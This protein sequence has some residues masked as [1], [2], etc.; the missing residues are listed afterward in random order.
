MVDMGHEEHDPSR[1]RVRMTAVLW[2]APVVLVST[3]FCWAIVD[4]S[5]GHVEDTGG[6]LAVPIVIAIVALILLVTVFT[7]RDGQEAQQ[8]SSP[9]VTLGT[10]SLLILAC[11]VAVFLQGLGQR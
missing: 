6:L 9:L 3:I 2:T 8:C 5:M 4:L 11:V 1:G 10:V 7:A